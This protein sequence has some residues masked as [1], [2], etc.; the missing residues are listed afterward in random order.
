MWYSRIFQNAYLLTEFMNE[1]NITPNNCKICIH[2]G[3][4]VIFYYK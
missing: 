2:T 4:Y 1:H 3:S